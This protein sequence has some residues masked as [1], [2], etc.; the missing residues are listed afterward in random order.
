MCIYCVV[1]FLVV[2][3]VIHCYIYCCSLLLFHARMTKF[4][5]RN[6]FEEIY[7]IRVRKVNTRIQQGTLTSP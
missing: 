6:Y 7:N 2:F 1:H 4:D 3:I 5:V